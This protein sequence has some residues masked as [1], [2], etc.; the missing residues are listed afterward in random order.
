MRASAAWRSGRSPIENGP[1]PATRT[2]SLVPTRSTSGDHI[3][4]SK[5]PERT[6]RLIVA[7][8]AHLHRL[9]LDRRGHSVDIFGH[10][11]SRD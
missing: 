3:R 2:H 6:V 5:E 11:R 4:P 1:E 10:G 7:E 8:K 9:R